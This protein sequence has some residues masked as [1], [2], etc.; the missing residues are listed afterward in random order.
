MSSFFDIEFSPESVALARDG[1]PAA[2]EALYVAFEQPV[3]TLVRRLVPGR[4]VGDDLAQ[5]VFVDILTRLRQFDGRGSFA[6][7]VRAIA[8]NKCLMYL[9]SP[10]HRSLRWLD[11]T[12]SAESPLE[13]REWREAG[14][15]EQ[16]DL[17]RAFARLSDTGR[18]VVWLH[19]VEGYTHGEI[20]ALLGGTASLS[21]SQLARA[22]VRLRSLLEP[23]GDE[24]A[25]MQASTS[26]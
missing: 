3:R 4:A 18:L 21:K 12:V 16:V 15:G 20:G 23:D 26:C 24:P 8:V 19:D 25:C 17:E 5:D 14:E 7:W 1:D 2:A 11:A 13:S 9:R 10:W 6:G 22:H